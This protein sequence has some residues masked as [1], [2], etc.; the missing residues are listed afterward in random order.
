MGAFFAFRAIVVWLVCLSLLAFALFVCFAVLLSPL[1]LYVCLFLLFAGRWMLVC[2]VF[3]Q[4]VMLVLVRFGLVSF[5]FLGYHLMHTF[6]GRRSVGSSLFTSGFILESRGRICLH[7]T[8]PIPCFSGIG[9]VVVV[10]VIM[11]L[12]YESCL[13]SSLNV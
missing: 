2:F 10:V 12:L 3:P 1:G 13:F 7:F 11:Y 9:Y 6:T 8:S 5:S 4:L